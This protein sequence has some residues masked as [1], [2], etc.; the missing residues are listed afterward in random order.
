MS[1]WLYVADVE[2]INAEQLLTFCVQGEELLVY[3]TGDNYHI[4]ANRCPH[5]AVPLSN[6]YLVRGAIVCRLHGAKF[7]LQT[8]GCLRSPAY[9]N[10]RAY[11]SEVCNGQLYVDLKLSSE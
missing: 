7:D 1:Q 6:G 11:P 8:G 9:E 5:Q 3:R 4:Y 2:Q 10:L